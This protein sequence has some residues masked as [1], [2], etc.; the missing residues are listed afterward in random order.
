MY[1]HVSSTGRLRGPAKQRPVPTKNSQ[2]PATFLFHRP[3][4]WVS[5]QAKAQGHQ[6]PIGHWSNFL[7]LSQDPTTYCGWFLGTL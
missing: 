1:H 5:P 2:D 4:A 6:V 7:P 3:L